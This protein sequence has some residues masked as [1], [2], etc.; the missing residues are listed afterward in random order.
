MVGLLSLVFKRLKQLLKYTEVVILCI[1]IG[2]VDQF[3][4]HCLIP[5]DPWSR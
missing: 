3:N 4:N 5:L 2:D 1:I